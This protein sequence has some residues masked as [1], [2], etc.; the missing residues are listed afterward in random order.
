[1]MQ[2]DM[3]VKV[4]I[5]SEMEKTSVITP[6]DVLALTTITPKY[7][8][9]LQANIYKLRFGKFILRDMT[10]NRVLYSADPG[11]EE[12]QETDDSSRLIQYVLPKAFLRLKVVSITVEFKV[13]PKEMKNFR[14]I[15]RHYF[16]DKLIKSFDFTF[17]FCIPNSTNTWE[18]IYSMPE[19]SEGEMKEMVKRPNETKSDSF[20]FVENKL[21]MHNRAEYEYVG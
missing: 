14:M 16:R 18:L 4:I 7:L 19:L 12:K 17:G 10:A 11:Y 1:M 2:C 3:W 21:F 8:C 6:K 20:F 5:G 9:P 15:E 13:G